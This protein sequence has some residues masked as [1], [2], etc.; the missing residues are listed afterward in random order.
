MHWNFRITFMLLACLAGG[1]RSAR[2]HEDKANRTAEANLAAAQSAALGTTEPIQVG[3]S[4]DA[5]R[6]R[7]LVAQDL[8]GTFRTN[9]LNQ[10]A[11]APDISLRPL[12][13]DP[14]AALQVAARNSRSFQQAKDRLFSAALGLNLEQDAFQTAFAAS[15]AG[16]IAED[17]SGE[18]PV[19]GT[20]G[21]LPLQ[22]TRTF[23]NGIEWTG[24]LAVDLAKLLTQSSASSLG[25]LAD[26]GITIPLLRGSGRD[27]V[28]EPLRQAERDLLY[29]VMTF[30]RFKRQFAFDIL[31]GYWNVLQAAREIENARQNYDSLVR[32][33]KR[34]RR[35]A[36]AGR[37]PE[38][39]YDQT[40]QDELRA[41]S[42]WIDAREQ[43]AGRLDAFKI[44]LGLPPDADISLQE[45]VLDTIISALPSATD[46]PSITNEVHASHDVLPGF[47]GLDEPTAM[48]LA[49]QNR[50]DLQI[51]YMQ[52]DDARRSIR[53]ARDALRAELTLG[54][55]VATGDRRS[56]IGSADRDDARLA[57]DNRRANGFFTLD[58][59]LNRRSE[60]IAYRRS[61]LDLDAAQ[62]EAQGTEDRVKLEIREAIRQLVQTRE[63]F[64]IQEQAA[65]LAEQ[66]VR[67][68]DMFLEAGRAQIR[69]VLEARED[70]VSTRNALSRAAVN[71][72][73][74]ILRFQRDADLL[75]VSVD[76]ILQEYVPSTAPSQATSPDSQP[77][78]SNPE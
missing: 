70:L 68:T 2:W 1:C 17:R 35:L 73:I 54:G 40:V 43:Y 3:T 55:S 8:P 74:A 69:D 19:R 39:Q 7:L 31:S 48:Q 20:T 28:A 26:T 9:A 11:E 13:L 41:R 57:L 23:R 58:L 24:S 5:L 71:Y 64:R 14:I 33:R 56:S 75:T 49:L 15:L 52:I 50:L 10:E 22:A 60:R 76:G 30:E 67:S 36:D 16:D 65:A 51:A 59:P 78:E 42:R 44:E 53:V 72:R 4:A 18:E 12:H 46:A 61:L 29:A 62:R 63:A 77:N 34:A 27:I 37:L 32:S 47:P 66:R 45:E 25:I 6:A 21:S 38:F